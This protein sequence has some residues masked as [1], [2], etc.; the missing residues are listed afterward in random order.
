M[1]K[2]GESVL[3]WGYPVVCKEHVLLVPLFGM[4]R[5]YFI[6]MLCSVSAVGSCSSY[7][8]NTCVSITASLL[9]EEM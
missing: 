1:R 7:L 4:I 3:S 8:Q 2:D 9:E 6:C 5:P